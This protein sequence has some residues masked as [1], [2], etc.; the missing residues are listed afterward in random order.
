MRLAAG[1][2]HERRALQTDA[3][4]RGQTF[5]PVCARA[6]WALTFRAKASWKSNVRFPRA[7]APQSAPAAAGTHK[8][9]AYIA[10]GA[11]ARLSFELFRERRNSKRGVRWIKFTRLFLCR[12]GLRVVMLVGKGWWM[13]L[14]FGSFEM[15]ERKIAVIWNKIVSPIVW[16]SWNSF[17]LNMFSFMVA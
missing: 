5:G 1:K 15:S 11:S 14:F 12:S 13:V 17:R 4:A 16:F 10:G 6:R 3:R 2:P 9:N 8:E 7:R